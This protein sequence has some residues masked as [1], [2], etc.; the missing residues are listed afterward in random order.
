M[1]KRKFSDF[2]LS[3]RS[4]VRIA[5]RRDGPQGKAIVG[6][7]L[8]LTAGGGSLGLGV[9]CRKEGERG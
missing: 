2:F 3:W 7:K 1:E 6:T 4:L 8:V 9:A 5:Q